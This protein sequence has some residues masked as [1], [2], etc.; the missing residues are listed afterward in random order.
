MGTWLRVASGLIVVAGFGCESERTVGERL[1]PMVAL[2]DAGQ[3]V[4]GLYAPLRVAAGG[5]HRRIRQR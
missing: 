1:N 4:F 2:Q 5:L 3:P